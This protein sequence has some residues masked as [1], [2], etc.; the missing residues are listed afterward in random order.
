MKP[1]VLDVEAVSLA[2]IL[3]AGETSEVALISVAPTVQKEKVK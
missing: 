1:T 3:S 2:T